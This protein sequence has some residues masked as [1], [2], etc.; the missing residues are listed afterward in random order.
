[1]DRLTHATGRPKHLEQNLNTLVVDTDKNNATSTSQEKTTLPTLRNIA[2]KNGIKLFPLIQ[3]NEYKYRDLL[4]SSETESSSIVESSSYSDEDD[5]DSFKK[6]ASEPT[7][8]S[9]PTLS[10]EK[11]ST[12]PSEV[13]AISFFEH[14]PEDVFRKMLFENLIDLNNL[15]ATAKNLMHFASASKFNREYVRVLLTE[16][17]MHE[18]SFEITK[19]VIPNMIAK[20]VKNNKTELP[21]V[22]I[23]ELVHNYP[24]LTLDCSYKKKSKLPIIGSE[25]IEKFLHHP[26]LRGVRIINKVPAYD[27]GI[28]TKHRACNDNGLDLIY[29]LLTRKKSNPLKVDF[30]Y[31]NWMPPF[32]SNYQINEKSFDFIKKIQDSADNCSGL[33]FGEINLKRSLKNGRCYLLGE[34]DPA[35]IQ[36]KDYQFKFVKMMCNIALMHSA[37]AISLYSLS[38]SD[39]ELGLILDEIK[40]CDKSSLQHLDLRG[41]LIDK[42]AIESLSALLQSESTC[43]KTLLLNHRD[44][45]AEA[46]NILVVALKNN[47]S[48]ELILIKNALGLFLD[49]PIRNDKRVIFTHNLW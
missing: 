14:M 30:I 44:I 37:H 48:L 11:N 1:M 3:Q 49:H 24:Y 4:N 22:D 43:L 12:D 40:L 9:R 42:S 26:D 45:S 36:A 15:P 32:D 46:L 28:G 17:G 25:I 23:D 16:E 33:T 6:S 18:V 7:F 21:Q 29:S 39:G 10:K 20:L 2:E 35:S 5:I 41:N 19:S 34:N 38:L 13:H 31:R 27:F 47:Q 8:S